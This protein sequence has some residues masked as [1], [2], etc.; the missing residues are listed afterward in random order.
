MDDTLRVARDVH[1]A[2]ESLVALSKRLVDSL[3]PEQERWAFPVN[4]PATWY[5]AVVHDTT[6]RKN[7]GYRHTGID[8][9]WDVPPHGDVDR[10]QPI[11]S[12]LSKGAK[13]AVYSC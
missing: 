3:E 13:E 10:G 1:A 12:V 5:A 6:G 11:Y 4:D 8:L 7:D 9:N 2:A